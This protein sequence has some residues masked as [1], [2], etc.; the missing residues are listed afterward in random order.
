MLDENGIVIWRCHDYWH[1]LRPDPVNAGLLKEL[2]WEHYADAERNSLCTI[3][4]VPLH[5]L[6]V[7]LKAKLRLDAV[8]IVG[9]PG[10]SCRRVAFSVGASDG[11]SQIE[12]LAGADIDVVVAGDIN[13][14]EAC[15][16][17]RDAAQA[18]LNKGYIVIGHANSEEPG[19]KY[20]AEWLRPM[21]PNSRITHVPA[22]D[23][24]RLI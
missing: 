2:E 3:P 22:G 7:F 15:E 21:L 23:P 9:N 14:W 13:E 6:A 12:V 11:R 24:F 8:Q 16:Y 17:V 4:P 10:M 19:M 20:L 18:G 1:S 5:E